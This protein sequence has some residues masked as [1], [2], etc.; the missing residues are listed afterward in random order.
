M[1]VSEA[2]FQNGELL[3]APVET[4]RPGERL[5]FVIPCNANQ[6]GVRRVTAEL[7]SR[8]MPQ[9]IRQIKNNRNS[10]SLGKS[11][12]QRRRDAETAVFLCAS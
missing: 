2:Q 1:P 6:Q 11:L 9:P 10:W 3:F 4:L 8:N 5:T 7:I 12:A